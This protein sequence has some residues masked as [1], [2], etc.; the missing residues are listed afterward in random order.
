MTMDMEW[1]RIIIPQ[2]FVRTLQQ[3]LESC[4]FVFITAHTGW[5]KTSVVK[6][7]LEERP[8]TYVSLWARDALKRAA[9]DKT[10]L[11]ILDDF[12]A[13]Y[14]YEDGSGAALSLL[15]T[16]PPDTRCVLLSRAEP[17]DW[18]LPFLETGQMEHL[19]CLSLSLDMGEIQSLLEDRGLPVPDAVEL[20]RVQELTRGNPSLVV[21]LGC[22]L[23]TEHP[24]TEEDVMRAR[25]NFFAHLTRQLFN[26]WDP[27]EQRLMMLASF[28]DSL[29]VEMARVLTG[30]PNSEAVLERMRQTGSFLSQEGDAYRFQFPLMRYYLQHQVAQIYR[31]EADLRGVYDVLSLCCQLLDDYDRA[32][33]YSVQAKNRIRTTELMTAYIRKDPGAGIRILKKIYRE[34][35][36]PERQAI[37][38]LICG[39]SMV[40]AREG[41]VEE[42]E[43]L[44]EELADTGAGVCDSGKTAQTARCFGAY[45]ALYLPH[46]SSAQRQ[47][48]LE[49]VVDEQERGTLRLPAFSIT[50]G[51]PSV[52][53][54]LWDLSDWLAEDDPT[55]QRLLAQQYGEAAS[56][57]LRLLQ[58]ERVYEKGAYRWEQVAELAT[59]QMQAKDEK[60]AGLAFA[61]STLAIRVV[62]TQQEFSLACDVARSLQQRIKANGPAELL[63]YVNAVLCRVSLLGDCVYADTWYAENH[64]GILELTA[65]DR[66]YG[67]TM[68]RCHIHHGEYGQANGILNHLMVYLRWQNRVLDLIEALILS[69]I[70]SWWLELGGWRQSLEEAIELARPYGY[71]AVFAELGTPLLPLLK[72]LAQSGDQ[73]FQAQLQEVAEK[74][75]RRYPGYLS[76]FCSGGAENSRFSTPQLDEQEWQLLTEICRQH[77]N[78]QIRENMGLS[79]RRFTKL[80]NSLYSKLN[81]KSRKRIREI[82]V[83]LL[84]KNVTS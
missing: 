46:R 24:F 19:P 79:I 35:P 83:I 76:P 42:A 70:C 50:D 7:L 80:T 27:M 72:K 68:A 75:A 52:L 51:Q 62:C 21:A 30:N 36:E 18:L 57:V 44:Q 58:A 12:H 3:A 47:D 5:G 78:E 34:I 74:Q 77:T 15:R 4:T 8:H 81:T 10:G 69:A 64:R 48:A 82:G 11:I 45:L 14:D 56:D 63:P 31:D 55:F 67:L 9:A 60:W 59:I 23:S 61:A 29:T 84:K 53:R 71:T 41:L 49:H 13:L 38:E 32:V 1:N 20:R 25:Q 33:S 65:E 54:G 16:L 43:R 37:P 26:Y 28:F 2:A 39:M 40:Y 73:E 6:T 66:Y 22:E 17:P